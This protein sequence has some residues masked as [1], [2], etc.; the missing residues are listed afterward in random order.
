MTARGMLGHFPPDR[1]QH[2]AGAAHKD[3]AGNKYVTVRL[4]LPDELACAL[5]R[6]RQRFHC[7]IELA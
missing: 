1:W 3:I 2:R 4:H 7:G 5:F 6:Q